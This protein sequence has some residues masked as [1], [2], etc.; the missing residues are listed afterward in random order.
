MA[1]V[2]PCNK[3]VID[4]KIAM[5]SVSWSIFRKNVPTFNAQQRCKALLHQCSRL[6]VLA[7]D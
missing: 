6:V 3:G 5:I 4:D 2:L 7:V 1:A